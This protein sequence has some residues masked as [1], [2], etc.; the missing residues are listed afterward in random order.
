[1]GPADKASVLPNDEPPA[2]AAGLRPNRC[3]AGGAAHGLSQLSGLRATTA[4][5]S[6]LSST[7]RAG[8]LQLGLA[9]PFTGALA[10][11]FPALREEEPEVRPTV[12]HRR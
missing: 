12:H 7:W 5:D 2:V 1:M 8:C 10:G 11:H 6:P 4:A 3:T 9:R